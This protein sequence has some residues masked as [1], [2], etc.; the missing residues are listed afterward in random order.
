MKM[1]IALFVSALFLASGS[2]AESDMALSIRE[3]WSNLTAGRLH[4][5]HLQ[6]ASAEPFAG[7]IEW[8][9]MVNNAVVGRG[10]HEISQA[11]PAVLI[12]LE[13]PPV[14]PGVIVQGALVAVFVPAGQTAGNKRM[15][16]VL[17][18]FPED[19]LSESEQWVKSLR[20][21]LF[22]P[23]GKTAALFEKA[24]IPHALIRDVEALA[25]EK[26]G[27]L[28]VGEGVSLKEYR[29][30]ADSVMKAVRSGAGVL[31]LALDEGEWP[32]PFSE[33]EDGF[34]KDI[35][36]RQADVISSL[37]KRLD[38][39]GWAPDGK[40]V[41]SSLRVEGDRGG[42]MGV[43]RKDDKGWPWVEMKAAQGGKLVICGFAIVEK[44]DASPTPRFLLVKLLEQVDPSRGV[45]KN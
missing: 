39:K 38:V 22:D 25:E 34:F 45:Q 9:F 6:A 41:R 3:P 21:R 42:V 19:P 31:C 18:F 35:H 40:S 10:E 13:V 8:Q 5:F 15:D 33:K 4:E 16:R 43:F 17:W 37:D 12:R 20:I 24:K 30:L 27:V 28:V 7:R 23:A 2:R 14:K 29:G 44:W 1:A 11:A 26:D 36:F 32:L